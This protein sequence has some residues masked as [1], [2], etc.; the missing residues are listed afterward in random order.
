MEHTSNNELTIVSLEELNIKSKNGNKARATCPLCSISRGN[1]KDPSV[2]IDLAAGVGYCHHC[3][4]RF[5]IDNNP[6]AFRESFTSHRPYKMSDENLDLRTHLLPMDDATITYLRCRGISDDVARAAGICSH[7]TWEDGDWK[8][9]VA[10]PFYRGHKVLNVQYKM[11]DARVK[12]FLFEAGGEMVPWN[13]DCIENGDGKEPL[14][15][16]EGMMDALALMESGFKKVVSVPNGANSKMSVFEPFRKT[17]DR[18][19][20]FIVFAGDTDDK[21]LLLRDHVKKFFTEKDVCF[22]DW[23]C[24]DKV[25]K[26]ANELLLSSGTDAIVSCIKS[27]QLQGD[28]RLL[29][30]GDDD[31]D[32]DELLRNGMPT[33]SAIGLPGFD[34]IVRFEP[35]NLLLITG[36]PGSGKSTLVNYI[37]VSLLRIYGWKTLFFSPEKLPVKYHEAE[38]ISLITGKPFVKNIMPNNEYVMAKNRLRGKIMYMSEEVSEVRDLITLAERAVRINDIKVLVIDPFIYLSIPS[39]PGSSETQRIAGMLKDIMLATRRL[40]IVV[41]L[42][43]HPRKPAG[44]NPTQPSLYEVAGS[45]NF[46][47]FCDAGIIL[48]RVPGTKNLVKVTSGKVRR[49][50]LGQLGSVRIA[51]DREC[52]RYSPCIVSNGVYT[53]SYSSFN[54]DMWVFG[55]DDV[56]VED[57]F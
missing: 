9:W 55:N 38:L 20:G 4:A 44:D 56:P 26:D 1:P 41:I 36:Y 19:F 15:I 25:A 40:N 54:R 53:N 22:V 24:G 31:K 7:L 35:G 13:I 37:V 57:L 5:K 12:R 52:G 16:T 39:I 11:A 46:Y 42:V 18:N 43:A 6:R 10:F 50:F 17:I 27:A 32:I 21:G 47:N 3:G 23:V 34:N 49:P 28:D 51:Y 8:H 2:A 45:A 33:G 14:M 29:M 48:E 30:L